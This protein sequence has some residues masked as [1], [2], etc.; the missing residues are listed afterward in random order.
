MFLATPVMRTVDRIKH[1]ST[2]AAMTRTR[3]S[4]V[5]RFIL[6]NMLERSRQVKENLHIFKVPLALKIG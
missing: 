2:R 1:P 5:S 4:L 6:A 3:L